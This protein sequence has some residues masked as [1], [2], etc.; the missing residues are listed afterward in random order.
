MHQFVNSELTGDV[1][2]S[3]AL[4]AEP[5]RKI[6]TGSQSS[7]V[8]PWRRQRQNGACMQRRSQQGSKSGDALAVFVEDQVQRHVLAVALL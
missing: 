4:D 7:L 5:V 2:G 6:P 3:V 8:R 1:Q